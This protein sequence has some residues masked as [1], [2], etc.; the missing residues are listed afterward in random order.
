M[1]E[2]KLFLGQVVTALMT[3]TFASKTWRSKAFPG[4]EFN[5]AAAFSKQDRFGEHDSDARSEHFRARAASTSSNG[6]P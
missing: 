1:S 4:C 2:R 6:E 5:V 3:S